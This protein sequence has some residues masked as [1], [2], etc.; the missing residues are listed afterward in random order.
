MWRRCVPWPS[1][2]RLRRSSE[3][4]RARRARMRSRRARVWSASKE[5]AMLAND[6]ARL[7]SS[8]A[9]V[10]SMA[11]TVAA[12]SGCSRRSGCERAAV[13]FSVHPVGTPRRPA[14][15]GHCSQVAP[16]RRAA[17]TCP[18]RSRCRFLKR[19]R[20]MPGGSGCDACRLGVH[21]AVGV[22]TSETRTATAAASSEASVSADHPATGSP[23]ES[24]G[25]AP[26]AQMQGRTM[27]SWSMVLRRCVLLCTTKLPAL[28]SKAP[29][30]YS[31]AASADRS[32][33]VNSKAGQCCK[34][35]W[36]RRGTSA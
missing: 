15:G 26:R 3:S 29:R 8:S 31:V 12:D 25:M 16:A 5:D 18:D 4:C 28:M 14:H 36:C 20:T 22:S 30:V 33:G 27:C 2:G 21:Q 35:G 23:K 32:R 13:A 19:Y 7:S 10:S 17:R 1:Q 9:S 34:D 6:V 11:C 24:Q